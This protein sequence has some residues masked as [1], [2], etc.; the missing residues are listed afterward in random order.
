LE[1]PGTEFWQR[2]ADADF[3]EPE[4]ELFCAGEPSAY[5]MMLASTLTKYAAAHQLSSRVNR[6]TAVRRLVERSKIKGR[7]DSEGKTHVDVPEETVSQALLAD[8]E[9]NVARLL[10]NAQPVLTELLAFLLVTRYGALNAST[11]R[12]ILAQP[13]V[14]AFVAAGFVV[15]GETDEEGL[16]DVAYRYARFCFEQYFLKHKSEILTAA[17]GGRSHFGKR[18]NII[19]LRQEIADQIEGAKSINFPWKPLGKTVLDQ[20]PA[21]VELPS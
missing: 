21:L 8:V 16:L 7:I 19:E 9:Y 13:D 11:C 5:Q 12:R 1:Q 14:G 20:L 2:Y 15:P 18:D 4:D 3:P 6:Q 10:V 17:R